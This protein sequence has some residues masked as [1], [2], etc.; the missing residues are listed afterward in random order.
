MTV[1]A[2]GKLWEEAL[3][4]SRIILWFLRDTHFIHIALTAC[5]REAHNQDL[6]TKESTPA[7]EGGRGAMGNQQITQ[8]A[9]RLPPGKIESILRTGRSHLAELSHLWGIYFNHIFQLFHH[10]RH[11]LTPPWTDLGV[12]LWSLSR[13]HAGSV[14]LPLIS[15]SIW[16]GLFVLT[17]LG[18]TTSHWLGVSYFFNGLFGDLHLLLIYKL[19]S[20]LHHVR[21]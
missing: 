13:S 1:E 5:K 17:V 6:Q 4:D 11:F 2:L 15:Y 20:Q 8:S 19:F 7:L 21:F 18:F 3:F 16:L 9:P 12:P 14:A 10:P